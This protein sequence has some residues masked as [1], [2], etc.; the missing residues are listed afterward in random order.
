MDE[1]HEAK[2]KKSPFVGPNNKGREREV[3]GVI[4]GATTRH[5]FITTGQYRSFV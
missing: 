1:E 5:C 4:Q 3:Q 2:K